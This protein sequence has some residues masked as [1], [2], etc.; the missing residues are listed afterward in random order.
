MIKKLNKKEC[1]VYLLVV[2]T[3]VLTTNF[4][5]LK[6]GLG[7]YI[8]DLVYHMLRIESVKDALLAWEYPARVNSIY[9]GGYGYGSSLFYPDIFLIPP[10]IFRI[11][12]FS[13][14]VS[15]K[16]YVL[17]LAA[18]SATTT[19]FSFRYI[20]Q[21]R[22][23]A[24]AGT[25]LLTLSQFYIAD[26]IQRAGIS[27][28]T[29]CIFLPV[30][31][32][33]IYDF[34]ECEGKRVYLIG[35]AFVGMVL[36][37]TIMTVIGLVIIC[38]A[39]L[40][41]LLTPTGRKNMLQKDKLLSLLGT[42]VL[43]VLA[44]SYYIF[45]MLEQMLSGEFGYM[46]PWAKIGDYTQPFSQFF[47]PVGT[48]ENISHVG[49]GIPIL[50]LL[51]CRMIFG[52]PGRRWTD[53]FLFGGIL[54][55]I[56]STD[57]V[58]W[59]MFNDTFLNILQFTFRLHPYGLCFL[60]VGLMMYFAEKCEYNQKKAVV[61][62]AIITI[63]FGIWQNLVVCDTANDPRKPVGEETLA[64]YTYYVGK[65]EWLP[66]GVPDEVR[67]GEA[68]NDVLCSHTE[69]PFMQVGYNTYS[70][71]KE[72]RIQA[73]YVL[74][75]IYYKGYV[76]ELGSADGGQT[77]LEVTRSPEGLTRVEVPEGFAGTIEV[78]YN[79]T[80]VQTFSNVISVLTILSLVSVVFYK[81]KKNKEK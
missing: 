77:K 62:I 39:F 16:L 48:F 4:T 3:V 36:S 49:I 42:A 64:E 41:A 29:A 40:C 19:Y 23:Y 70:F 9:F 26:I 56:S 22:N 61:Y 43:S 55:F 11:M 17:I 25:L 67:Y 75:L 37:H 72:D 59:E 47:N 66:V 65:G 1:I 53:F 24:V 54:I 27:Q 14:V 6:W 21:N 35:I 20:I 78:R 69:I 32:A 60:V 28:Y 18:L 68:R 45:P 7:G 34:I 31:V 13:P 81:K 71:S 58:P 8:E 63:G 10:A 57:I 73:E 44:V 50:I 76:A 79:G 15:W 5:N 52:K 2:L 51:G 33:G 80:L 74:P 12:G 30:L 38:I 46:E